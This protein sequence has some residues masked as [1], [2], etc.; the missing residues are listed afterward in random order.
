M[1]P[2][3][4]LRVRDNAVGHRLGCY[5]FDFVTTVSS[6][7]VPGEILVSFR[8]SSLLLLVKG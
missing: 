5:S 3:D 7:G 1:V 8:L 2:Q 4:P 6:R